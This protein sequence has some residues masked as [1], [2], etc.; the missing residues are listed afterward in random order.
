MF[1]F[2]RTDLIYP[3]FFSIRSH[4]SQIFLHQ[5]SFI[6]DFSPSDLIY[7]RFFSFRSHLSQIFSHQISF[8]PDFFPSDL[9]YPMPRPSPVCNLEM[10]FNKNL[11]FIEDMTQLSTVWIF[12]TF[13]IAVP[14][15]YPWVL[16]SIECH[17]QML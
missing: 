15:C 17:G 8:I 13:N 14:E 2:F 9:I 5:I 6:P 12:T 7:P 4:L 1:R 10:I 3:R 16:C 11:T